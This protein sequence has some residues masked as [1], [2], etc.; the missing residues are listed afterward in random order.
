MSTKRNTTVCEHFSSIFLG[1]VFFDKGGW[2]GNYIPQCML[3][4]GFLEFPGGLVAKDL[5]LSLLW[6]RFNSWPRTSACH[7]CSPQKKKIKKIHRSLNSKAILS[8]T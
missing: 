2:L 4:I 6:L 7:G 1:G 8:R 5:A 3:K